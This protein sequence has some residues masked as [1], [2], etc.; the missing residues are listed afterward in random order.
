VQG[1]VDLLGRSGQI[2]CSSAANPALLV[3]TSAVPAMIHVP[4]I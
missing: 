4:R 1:P 3:S 2:G